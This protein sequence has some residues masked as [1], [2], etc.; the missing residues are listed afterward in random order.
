MMWAAL[1]FALL[2]CAA[3]QQVLPGLSY[4]T[5]TGVGDNGTLAVGVEAPFFLVARQG[6][7]SS[8]EAACFDAARIRVA[9]TGPQDQQVGYRYTSPCAGGEFSLVWTP[10]LSGWHTVRVFIDGAAVQ[11]TPVTLMVS[12]QS[13]RQF[14]W[15]E[16]Q[17]STTFDFEGLLRGAK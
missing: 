10:C 8:G 1:A 3:G 11:N 9:I 16:G 12:G 15:G 6:T 5:G 2:V 13:A 4:V 14:V 17:P 7:G